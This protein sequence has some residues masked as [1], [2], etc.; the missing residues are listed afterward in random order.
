MGVGEPEDLLTAI[1]LG[2]DMFDCVSPTR[3]GRHGVAYTNDGKINLR[4]SGFRND[5]EPLDNECECY[6]CKNF[7][8]GYIAHLLRENEILGM[9]LLSLHNLHFLVNLVDSA[10][11]A[12][13]NGNFFAFKDSFLA[14]YSK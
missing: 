5:H 4:N 13:K 7:S 1:S 12:I 8:K 9:R 2:V 6:A 14:R 11:T 10:R 3:L